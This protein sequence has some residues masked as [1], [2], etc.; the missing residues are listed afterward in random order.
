MKMMNIPTTTITPIIVFTTPT[1]TYVFYHHVIGANER[2]WFTILI[3]LR[4]QG[5]QSTW[6]HR[7]CTTSTQV[8]WLICNVI[9]TTMKSCSIVG[10]IG[11][12]SML[13]NWRRSMFSSIA[14]VSSSY[15]HPLLH[16]LLS[17]QIRIAIMETPG[18]WDQRRMIKATTVTAIMPDMVLLI[19][20]QE[21][22]MKEQQ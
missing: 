1:Q 5:I 9:T 8:M 2:Y 18:T 19:Q 4:M 17:F 7:R 15:L 20:I 3:Q 21:W 13:L 6:L 22:M 10:L 11:E 14:M 16:Y 12:C